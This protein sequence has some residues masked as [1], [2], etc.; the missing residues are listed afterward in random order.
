MFLCCLV[1]IE[2]G[3]PELMGL[4]CEVQYTFAKCSVSLVTSLL[5]VPPPRPGNGGSQERSLLRWMQDVVLERLFPCSVHRRPRANRGTGTCL[6]R[7]LWHGHP[8]HSCTESS[9]GWAQPR[10]GMSVSLGA[11]ARAQSVHQEQFSLGGPTIK[12]GK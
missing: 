9:R 10:D 2:T 6:P 12:H 11:P 4:L 7:P 8:F 3:P 1:A 5:S